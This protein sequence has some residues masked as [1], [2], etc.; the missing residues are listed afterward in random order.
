MTEHLI[1]L[2]AL[3]VTSFNVTLIAVLTAIEYLRRG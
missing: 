1:T 2:V 3:G